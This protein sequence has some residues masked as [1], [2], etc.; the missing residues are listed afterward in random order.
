MKN[1][2]NGLY[3]GIMFLVAFVLSMIIGNYLWSLY[4]NYIIDLR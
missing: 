3:V 2:I 1:N 4:I